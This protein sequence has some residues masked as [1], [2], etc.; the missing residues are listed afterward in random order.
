MWDKKYIKI[1]KKPIYFILNLCK[2]VLETKQ[3]TGRLVSLVWLDKLYIDISI[4]QVNK[5][6]TL[7]FTRCDNHCLRYSALDDSI[8]HA[9]F[10]VHQF[11]KH[12]PC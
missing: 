2:S 3:I 5:N 6:I 9:I 10:N 11:Y 4:H 1:N 7:S 12:R 8:S